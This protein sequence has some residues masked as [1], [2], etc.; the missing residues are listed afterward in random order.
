LFA[1]GS[2]PLVTAATTV[3][4]A[5]RDTSNTFAFLSIAKV[6]SKRGCYI[7]TMNKL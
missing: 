2:A 7:A 4:A 1:S 6:H 5:K 3:S